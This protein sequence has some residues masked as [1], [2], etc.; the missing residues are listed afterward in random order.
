MTLSVAF[1]FAS[2][3][4][5]HGNFTNFALMKLHEDF[6]EQLRELLPDEWEALADAI[7]TSEPSI[8]VRVND[9]RGV[10]VP[11]GCRRVPWCSEGF[12]L[13][14]RPAFTF[15]PDWH[16]GR[17]YV[18]DASSMF[19]AH[20][21]RSH[22]PEPVR[23]LDL[24]AAPGGKT[25]A[26]I[27]ALLPQSL[28]VANEIV[29]PRAR[30]LADNV[31]RWG[32]PRCVVTSNAPAQI[33]K[34]THFFD[35]IAADVPC[36]GEGMM[37]KDDE[38]VAQWSP[39]LVEQCAQRQ[40][41]ILT[42]VWQALRPGGLLI[43]STC[44]Y[45]RQENELM[46]DFIVNELGATSLEVP[47]EPEWNIHPAIGSACHCYRFMPHRV[48]GEGLFM[49]VFRKDGDAPRQDIRVKDKNA[50]K[51]D[52]IGKNWL[53]RPDDYVVEQQGDLSIAVPQDIRREVTAL[54]TSLNVLHAG[55]ELATVMGRKTVPHHALAMSTA[56]AADAFPVCE[57][58]YPTALRYLRGESI[59]VDGPRGYVLVAHQGAIL[60]FAN[61]L[62][63]R[64]NNLYPKPQRILSTHLPATKPSVL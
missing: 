50:K 49:A 37:R 35:V 30:V 45:N 43:Y 41:E 1:F 53:S 4:V 31:I 57:V 64:A 16:A 28:V 62:G 8:T 34:L 26:A 54:R 51:A 47:V 23:Y 56:R 60:G 32:D 33:G 44:T 10:E 52:E 9:A 61:N 11:K 42:D 48:D 7:T 59:T 20:A 22:I 2:N 36:S 39:A 58:D 12:Y 19:I 46:A 27:Q 13:T 25:T 3:V 55:V 63:N 15:D 14:D 17:Y 40:R 6:I 38:A 21:I 29:P 18:Q 24:C 5:F